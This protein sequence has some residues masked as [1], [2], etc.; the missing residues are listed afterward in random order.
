M[1]STQGSSAAEDVDRGALLDLARRTAEEA[2]SL[3]RTLRRGSVAVASTKTSRTDVVTGSDTAAEALVR[4]RLGRAR[5]DDGL[6]A[7]EG[8]RAATRSGLTWVVD[9]IDGTVNYLYGIPWYAVSI[10]VA[11]PEGT[12]LGVVHNPETGHTWTAVRGEGAYLGDQRLSVGP[13]P[14]LQEALVATGF[15]Y[16]SGR[17]AEQAAVLQPLLPDVRDIRRLGAA[18]LD[19][20][21]VASGWVDAYFERGLQPWDLAAGRVVAQEA[22]AEVR[23]E[24]GKHADLVVAASEPLATELLS[25]VAASL[26]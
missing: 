18:S 23:V 10:A 6:L 1:D 25:R 3:V 20:C 5:P 12:L 26:G 7:E 9:P 16:A 14:R 8:S 15:G 19:L 24:A 21:A 13:P 2:G 11:D 4:D 17:R 22:G